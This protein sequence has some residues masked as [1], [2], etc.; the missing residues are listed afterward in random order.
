MFEKSAAKQ[1]KAKMLVHF[2]TSNKTVLEGEI[3]IPHSMSFADFLNSDRPFIEIE[4]CPE[5]TR[6]VAKSSIVEARQVMRAPSEK[7]SPYSIL[8]IQSGASF[9]E[10][11]DAWKKRV[12]ACH[13]DKISSLGVDEEIEYAAR[14]ATQKINMAY[15][16]IVTHLREKDKVT[17]A[18]VGAAAHNDSSFSVYY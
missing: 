11:K 9:Q 1:S 18:K 3:V 5:E 7:G 10:V 16:E 14:K 17:K 8:R 4:T 15:D 6:L 13:P 2:Q 12:K